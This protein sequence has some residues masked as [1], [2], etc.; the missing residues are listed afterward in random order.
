MNERARDQDRWTIIS[1]ILNSK[2]MISP[3]TSYEWE[4]KGPRQVCNHQYN[5]EP[6]NYNQ[7]TYPLYVRKQGSRNPWGP[8]RTTLN[9]PITI[10][11]LTSYEWESKEQNH[12]HH[13]ELNHPIIFRWHTSYEWG[14]KRP[15]RTCKHELFW[16]PI[17][18]RLTNYG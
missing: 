2:I 10:R 4:G 13:S 5:S 15:G 14:S 16:I 18:T 17:T 8:L 3:H 6:L 12:E 11:P 7:T 1:I 9:L